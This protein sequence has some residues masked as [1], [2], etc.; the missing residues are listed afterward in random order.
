M[1]QK[2]TDLETERD[3]LAAEIGGLETNISALRAELGGVRQEAQLEVDTLKAKNLTHLE[4]LAANTETIGYLAQENSSQAGVGETSSLREAATSAETLGEEIAVLSEKLTRSSEEKVGMTGQIEELR[5]ENADMA[6]EIKSLLMA[7]EILNSGILNVTYGPKGPADNRTPIAARRPPDPSPVILTQPNSLGTQKASR[8]PQ[9]R[10]SA[11]PVPPR[12]RRPV[13]TPGILASSL[14]PKSTIVVPRRPKPLP[15]VLEVTEAT[16]IVP[17]IPETYQLHVRY[18]HIYSAL[19]KSRLCDIPPYPTP[20]TSDKTVSDLKCLPLKEPHSYP[21]NRTGSSIELFVSSFHASTVDQQVVSLA[22]LGL[23]G[24]A[25]DPVDIYAIQ[26]SGEPE[27]SMSI[28]YTSRGIATFRTCLRILLAGVRAQNC[29]AS[30]LEVIWEVTHFPPAVISLK[31]LYER[32]DG[33]PLSCA[34]VAICVGELV[35]KVV[36]GWSPK[37]S[38]SLEFSR[39]IFAGIYNLTLRRHKKAK[40]GQAIARS[41]IL[42]EVAE[43]AEGS[44]TSRSV[45]N[46]GVCRTAFQKPKHMNPDGRKSTKTT[47]VRREAEDDIESTFLALAKWGR[48]DSVADYYFYRPGY[49]SEEYTYPL[50]QESFLAFLDSANRVEKFKVIGPQQLGILQPPCITLNRD[51]YV[52]VYN[53][54][55]IPCGEVY[56]SIWNAISGE[57]SLAGEDP[58]QSLLQILQ[59]I[60]KKRQKEGTWEV[61]AWTTEQGIAGGAESSGEGIVICVD[62]SISMA[63]G[64]GGGWGSDSMASTDSGRTWLSRVS[65]AKELFEDLVARMAAYKL[66]TYLGLLTTPETPGIDQHPTPVLYDVKDKLKTIYPNGCEE[67]CKTLDKALHMLV[68]F[69]EKHPE[70]KLRIISYRMG[71]AASTSLPHGRHAK[72]FVLQMSKLTGGYTIRPENRDAFFQIPLLESLLDIRHRPNIQRP[73]MRLTSLAFDAMV[74]PDADFKS[75]FDCPPIRPHPHQID[76][77]ILL[78]HTVRLGDSTIT[79]ARPSELGRASGAGRKRILLEELRLMSRTRIHP[80]YAPGAFMLYVDMGESYPRQPPNARFITPILHPNI[81]KQGRICHPIL[82]REW[83]PKTRIYEV[84]QQLWGMLMVVEIR[85]SVNPIFAMRIWADAESGRRDIADHIR[86]FASRTRTQLKA[87]IG[88]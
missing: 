52:S 32:G 80:P 9:L 64:M 83:D 26:L 10:N 13:P 38:E 49:P 54:K 71:G 59:P 23:R 21:G 65:E 27:S 31:E 73:V 5:R 53:P 63:G 20:L 69:H 18:I 37:P 14:E 29:L 24:T 30:T 33:V 3:R 88:V 74:V 60:I 16:P 57:Q 7:N 42:A 43:A 85:D 22:D 47:R 8:S 2:T 34:I 45:V 67:I 40:K 72:R 11:A 1:V 19:S 58:G 79:I 76:S 4:E 46:I 17:E 82:D 56:P 41:V 35:Q 68:K 61:D 44:R 36:T 86:R 48:Y 78:Q 81:T 25:Q 66:P 50:Q 62:C 70:A 15:V 84:L 55:S 77:F 51:G 6:G 75:R 39:P 87:E 12:P 28:R